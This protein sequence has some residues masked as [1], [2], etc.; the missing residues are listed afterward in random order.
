MK[1]ILATLALAS[2]A[3]SAHAQTTQNQVDANWRARADQQIQVS[4]YYDDEQFAHAT[5]QI[6][7]RVHEQMCSLP[8]PYA[9][10]GCKQ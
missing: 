6:D 1:T 9:P 10:Q 2:F 5:A 8:Y 3:L 4:N 7:A